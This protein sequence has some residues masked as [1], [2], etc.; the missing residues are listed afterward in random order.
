M[1]KPAVDSVHPFSIL[2]SDGGSSSFPPLGS[3]VNAL[4]VFPRFPPSFWGFEGVLEVIP[5]KAMTAPLGL[6]TVA[7]L[8]PA[9]G[10][11]P[12][13]RALPPFTAT[14]EAH[15]NWEL[16]DVARRR[17]EVTTRSSSRCLFSGQWNDTKRFA[18][19]WT[20]VREFCL[21]S[22]A[23]AWHFA[24]RSLLRDQNISR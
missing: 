2:P 11:S 3:K 15:V 23:W 20:V 24:G 19:P 18:R 8:C 4:Q 22:Q 12:G 5:E 21:M 10:A 14:V 16:L 1:P 6:I 9:P 17:L 7:A 13:V